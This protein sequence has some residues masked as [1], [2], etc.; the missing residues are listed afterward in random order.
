[1][2]SLM[3]SLNPEA[4]L[5]TLLMKTLTVVGHCD[6]SGCSVVNYCVSDNVC[7]QVSM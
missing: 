5:R 4:V 3:S 7:V 6:M 2:L 1:M